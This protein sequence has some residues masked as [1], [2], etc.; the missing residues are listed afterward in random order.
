AVFKQQWEAVKRVS[1][2]AH[3][4]EIAVLR[5]DAAF[6]VDRTIED[7]RDNRRKKR[8]IHDAWHS[9]HKP[10]AQMALPLQGWLRMWERGVN[11]KQPKRG[12]PHHGDATLRIRVLRALDRHGVRVEA[13][14]YWN[15]SGAA[16]VLQAVLE[17]VT[18]RRTPIKP[19]EWKK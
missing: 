19:D 4:L 3:D 1:E 16:T 14:R 10:L 2:A 11:S 18:G 15:Q 17:E 9:L 5:A 7:R 6:R 8:F 12:R 13:S